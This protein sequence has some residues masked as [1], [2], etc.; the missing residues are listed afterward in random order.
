[1]PMCQITLPKL[2][3]SS[4]QSNMYNPFEGLK[5]PTSVEKLPEVVALIGIAVVGLVIAVPAA[6]WAHKQDV[7]K[8]TES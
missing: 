6:L 3:L 5:I 2:L 1:M 7:T 8:P 4:E